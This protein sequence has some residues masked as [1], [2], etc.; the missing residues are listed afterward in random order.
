MN[1]DSTI[2]VGA[3][4]AVHVVSVV[5]LADAVVL[6]APES[7]GCQRKDACAFLGTRN[8]IAGLTITVNSNRRVSMNKLPTLFLRSGRFAE[9]SDTE[10]WHN[11][12]PTHQC[13]EAF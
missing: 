2:V 1:C 12:A 13:R 10:E 3:L 4:D 8:R 11:A 5:K 7:I 9:R 6:V